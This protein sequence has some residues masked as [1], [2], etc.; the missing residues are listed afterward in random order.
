MDATAPRRPV[1]AVGKDP[2]AI[3]RRDLLDGLIH[4]YDIAA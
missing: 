2:P 3:E 4:E 1:R